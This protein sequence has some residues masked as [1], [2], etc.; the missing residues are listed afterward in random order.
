MMMRTTR[1]IWGKAMKPHAG[2][3]KIKPGKEVRSHGNDVYSIQT[4]HCTC[5]TRP[6]VSVSRVKFTLN[7][8]IAKTDLEPVK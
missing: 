6:A 4:M 8:H 1:P 2:E 5:L 7:P 3:V